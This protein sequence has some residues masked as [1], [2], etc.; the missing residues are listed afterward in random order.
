MVKHCD[1]LYLGWTSQRFLLK[2]I[3]LFESTPRCKESVGGQNRWFLSIRSLPS[4]LLDRIFH[5]SPRIESL[6]PGIKWNAS[7]LQTDGNFELWWSE[8]RYALFRWLEAGDG[9]QPTSRCSNRDRETARR[10]RLRQTFIHRT[11]RMQGLS[12][13]ITFTIFFS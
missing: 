10:I 1:S 4:L 8:G 11:R 7:S 5:Q 9:R 12:S 6:H 13:C 3:T 2:S